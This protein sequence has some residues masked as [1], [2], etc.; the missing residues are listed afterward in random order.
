MI[1]TGKIKVGGVLEII[2][3]YFVVVSE[4]LSLMERGINDRRDTFYVCII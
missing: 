2:L 3:R 1:F 4:G